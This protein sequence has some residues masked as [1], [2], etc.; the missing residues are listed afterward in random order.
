MHSSGRDR[1]RRKQ[2]AGLALAQADTPDAALRL[3]WL[4]APAH[5][6]DVLHRV[7][8]PFNV[9][10]LAQTAGIAALEDHGH[11]ERERANNDRW[12]PWLAEQLG[13]LGLTVHPS[14]ANF[15]LVG[16]AGT[17]GRSA[18]AASTWLERQGVLAR[19]M[20]AYGLPHCLRISV[21]REDE[22][23]AVVE[24]LREFVA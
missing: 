1:Q 19:P 17:D 24:R 21:G 22:N 20:A 11:Q 4:Y 6:I 23:R 5:V 9:S 13:G 3:G 15:V 10:A 2:A 12:R 14:V 18:R 16:F 8:G 7:R